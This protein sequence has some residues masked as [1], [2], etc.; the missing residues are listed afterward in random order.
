MANLT[1]VTRI[2]QEKHPRNISK[3]LNYGT[4]GFRSRATELDHILYRM[5]VL[6]ALRSKSKDG[7]TIGVMIT[8]SHNPEEDNGVKLIDPLGEMLES[9]W[10]KHA[11]C[12]ANAGDEE[13]QVVL[14]EIVETFKIDMNCK[15][16]VAIGMDTRASSPGLNTAV[17]DGV[18]SVDGLCFDYGTITTPQLH[19]MVRCINTRNAYGMA[20]IEG[21]C[22]KLSK[23]LKNIW[24]NQGERKVYKPHIIVDCAN[25]VGAKRLKDIAER[26][27]KILS[28]EIRN[29]GEGKLNYRCGADYVKVNQ[30]GPEGIDCIEGQKY[31]S[32]DGDADRIVFYYTDKDNIFHLLDGDKVA[33]LIASYL[34]GLI[35]KCGL[36]LNL[37]IVQTAYANGNS[38]AYIQD[39]LKVPV[40][41]VCTGV[42]HLHR[43]ALE[44]EIGVYFEANG[45]GTILFSD[46]ALSKIESSCSS[47]SNESE[48]LSA[49]ELRTFVDLVNQTVGDSISDMLIVETILRDKDW[50]VAD[51]DKSYRNLAN[52]LLVV[53]VNDRSVFETTNAE[54]TVIK[55]TGLQKAIDDHVKLFPNGR[56]FVRPSGTEDVVRIY[57]ESDTQENADQLALAV[58]KS[59]YDLAGGTGNLPTL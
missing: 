41:C 58:A 24:Q 14:S 16:S 59:T 42:K 5:G 32:F 8:A 35:R 18:K 31:A 4:A 15:S 26:F 45:H 33:T 17:V 56:S 34:I 3:H 23:A 46:S 22:N 10:E 39:E 21:Y 47:S 51:W 49:N 20:T 54:R 57:A 6:A 37:G 28:I 13:F 52:R 11:T 43:K 38:T 7:D 27:D 44:F 12:L 53:K 55:P 48:K 30:R 19:Y 1:T 29:A 25:G 9:S 36:E 50:D 2:S 40:A